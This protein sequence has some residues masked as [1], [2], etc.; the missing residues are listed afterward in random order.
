MT[1]LKLKRPW[2]ITYDNAEE[3]KKLYAQRR[4]F[5][6]NL[7]YS[8]QEKRLGTEIMI[9]SKGLKIPKS[10]KMKTLHKYDQAA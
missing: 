5:E 9:A 2:V 10:I 4:L 3:I 1:A 7:K 8:L 6:F